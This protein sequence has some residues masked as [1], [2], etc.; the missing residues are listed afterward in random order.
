MIYFTRILIFVGVY[1]AAV[2]VACFNA[3]NPDY[4]VPRILAAVCLV[5]LGLYGRLKIVRE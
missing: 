4:G 5:T 2:A 1:N 3:G